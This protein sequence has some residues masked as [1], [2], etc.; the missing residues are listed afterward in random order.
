MSSK[1]DWTNTYSLLILKIKRGYIKNK[2]R[3][4]NFITWDL[5]VSL[6]VFINHKAYDGYEWTSLVAEVVKNPPAKQDTWVRSLGQE[7]PLKKG[8]ATHSSILAWKIPWTEEPGRLQSMGLQRV[9]Q[10][11]ATKHTYPSF[12]QARNLEVN[13]KS[14][15]SLTLNVKTQ[16]QLL[17]SKIFLK[18]LYPMTP[19]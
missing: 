4:T 8:M 16:Y 10:N 11:W 18:N 15:L 9:R 14:L 6:C 2:F 19:A 3:D 1:T 5:C 13:F 7:N 17:F 12:G